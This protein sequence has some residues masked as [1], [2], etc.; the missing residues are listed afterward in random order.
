MWAEETEM[1]QAKHVVSEYDEKNVSIADVECTAETDRAIL[2]SVNGGDHWVPKSQL[3]DDSE[4][5]SKKDS[6]KL[7]MSKWIAKQRGLWEDD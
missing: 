5:Y 2:V 3:H 6:G 7:V 4:V 1:N